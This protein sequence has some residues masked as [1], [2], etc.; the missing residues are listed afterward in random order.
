[1]LYSQINSTEACRQLIALRK[2]CIE[3]C[4]SS[5]EACLNFTEPS[6]GTE[7]EGCK[8]YISNCIS[9]CQKMTWSCLPSNYPVNTKYDYEVTSTAACIVIPLFLYL[10]FLVTCYKKETV[11]SIIDN[12]EPRLIP[13]LIGASVGLIGG[14]FSSFA[15]RNALVP[16]PE[17]FPQNNYRDLTSADGIAAM[18]G[19]PL[20]L[21]LIVAGAAAPIVMSILHKKSKACILHVYE[22]NLCTR[23]TEFTTVQTQDTQ[24]T[25]RTQLQIV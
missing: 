23:R 8:D 18:A 22:R 4:S 16:K 14:V 24:T 19:V 17:N 3:V 20:T 13:T 1:M 25:N 21:F 15:I 11:A 9:A 2:A 12:L 6:F 10:L 5:S 7:L